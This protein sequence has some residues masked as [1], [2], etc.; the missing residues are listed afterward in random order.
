MLF[1][2]DNYKTTFE[3]N[4]LVFSL[5]PSL[6]DKG[7]RS[8]L[9][10]SGNMVAILWMQANSDSDP[11]R[12]GD[13]SIANASFFPV[14]D[15][16]AQNIASANFSL[17]WTM[18]NSFFEWFDPVIGD[19]SVGTN[20]WIGGRLIT[21][22]VFEKNPGELAAICMPALGSAIMNLSEFHLLD[23]PLRILLISRL[24]TVGGG[25]IH[26]VAV[27]STPLHP[28]WR[29]G[30]LASL[31]IAFSYPNGANSTVTDYVK[32]TVTNQTQSI[33]PLIGEGVGAYFNEADA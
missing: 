18:F 1:Q 31:N 11:N 28:A 22:E 23:M 32:A 6:V 14:I 8:Y 33:D 4:K 24:S 27:D 3:F 16:A 30:G 20:V 2:A 15:Y 26:D 9:T 21:R 25:A 10:F 7:F 12:T 29:Q 19:I 17:Q 5:I 13:Y